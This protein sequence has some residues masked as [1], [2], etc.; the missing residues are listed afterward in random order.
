MK[1]LFLILFLVSININAYIQ[2]STKLS[3]SEYEEKVRKSWFYCI[4]ASGNSKAYKTEVDLNLSGENQDYIQK[5]NKFGREFITRRIE[6]DTNKTNQSFKIN[7]YSEGLFLNKENELRMNDR[8]CSYK[9]WKSNVSNIKNIL[10]SKADFK[11]P[12][13]VWVIKITTEDDNSTIAETKINLFN[14]E[15][16]NED[17]ENLYDKKL[18]SFDASSMEKYFIVNPSVEGIDNYISMDISRV[19]NDVSDD[20]FN[21]S[22][23]LSFIGQQ[24]CLLNLNGKNLEEILQFSISNKYDKTIENLSC[25]LSPKYIKHILSNLYL[26]GV[27]D[28]FETLDLLRKKIKI[29]Q[30]N[31]FHEME[32]VQIIDKLLNRIKFYYSYE[33]SKDIMYLLEYKDNFNLNGLEIIE[34]LRFQ[35]ISYLNSISMKIFDMLKRI[36]SKGNWLNLITNKELLGLKILGLNSLSQ[37]INSIV[38]MYGNIYKPNLVSSSHFDMIETSIKRLERNYLDFNENLRSLLENKESTKSQLEATLNSLKHFD[39]SIL[40]YSRKWESF[41]LKMFVP[42]NNIHDVLNSHK[43]LLVEIEKYFNINVK[44]LRMNL[45]EYFKKHFED[46]SIKDLFHGEQKEFNSLDDFINKFEKVIGEN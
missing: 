7:F 22:L 44:A 35:G 28:F 3:I 4:F 43:S 13:N 12:E 11:I 30:S 20:R 33:I 39:I 24:K 6:W 26:Y 45:N 42:H 9:Y 5:W 14:K 17:T 8:T 10:I 38:R 41:N 34:K 40:Y 36:E 21:W 2:L 32:K 37:E 29:N 23:N 16:T 15:Y 19:K 1:I 25:F 18:Y 31:N 46:P 27:G